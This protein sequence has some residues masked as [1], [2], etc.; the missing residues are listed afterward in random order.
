MNFSDQ[1]RCNRIFQQVVHKGGESAINYIKILQNTKDFQFQWEIV[2]NKDQLMHTFL[3]NLQ[4][5]GK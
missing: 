2:I 3:E 4:Q 5:G 1:S